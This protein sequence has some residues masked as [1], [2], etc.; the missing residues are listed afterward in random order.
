MSETKT[1]KV[2]F[3]TGLPRG[4]VATFKHDGQRWFAYPQPKI[5]ALSVVMDRMVGTI[6]RLHGGLID[7][8][9]THPE[10]AAKVAKLM[11]RVAT[12]QQ[13]ALAKAEAWTWTE[14]TGEINEDSTPAA[15]EGEGS[16]A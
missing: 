6:N 3:S 5:Q 13:L 12:T 2:K 7:W 8:M 15:P 14:R 1:K 9:N 10:D 16:D 4:A 11:G